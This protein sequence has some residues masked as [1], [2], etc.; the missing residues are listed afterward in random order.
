MWSEIQTVLSR[1]WTQVV[2]SISYDHNRYAK[3]A[4]I[5]HV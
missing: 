3:S 5:I 1:I 2:D 4:S